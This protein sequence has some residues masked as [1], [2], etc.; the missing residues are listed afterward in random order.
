MKDYIKIKKIK[1]LSNLVGCLKKFH[2]KRI[3]LLLLVIH[4]VLI[5]LCV[6]NLLIIPYNIVKKSLLGLRI[7]ILIFFIISL[8]SL[9]LIQIFRKRKK[10]SYGVYYY[11][12]Y[13]GNLISLGLCLINFLFILISCIVVTVRLKKYKGKKQDYKSSLVIDIFSLLIVVAKFFLWYY[14]ILLILARTDENLKDFID[15]KIRFYQ[16]Q[17]QKVVNVEL[18]VDNSNNSNNTNKNNQNKFEK[19]KEKSIDDDIIS[20]NKMEINS[21]K[22]DEKEIKKGDNDNASIDTK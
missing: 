14:E 1:K 6:M 22:F 11:I 15:A 4:I 20:S 2:S 5:I 13:F 18:S 10:I 9:I 3:E 16:S 19:V 21:E 12:G 17:N 8:I 7:V